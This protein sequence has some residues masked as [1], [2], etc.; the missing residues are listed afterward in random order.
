MTR[1]FKKLFCSA[2][3]KFV[4]GNL[5]KACTLYMSSVKNQ[6]LKVTKKFSNGG[7]RTTNTWVH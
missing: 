3:E 2:I 7:V 4:V 6:K 5:C 1:D